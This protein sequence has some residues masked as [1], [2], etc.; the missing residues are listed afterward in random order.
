MTISKCYAKTSLT[1]APNRDLEYISLHYTA[2]TTSR[3]GSA[4]N[5]AQWFSDGGNPDNPASSDFIVD[6]YEVVQYNED[7]EN[8]YSWCVG[9]SLY[10][11]PTTSLG[12]ILYGKA[13][14]RNTINIEICSNKRNTKS[15]RAEDKD[16][17]FTDAA[18]NNA[19]ALVK[20]LMARYKIP[21]DHVI[22][23]HHVTGKP[24]PAMWTHEEKELNGYYDFIAKIKGKPIAQQKQEQIS[25]KKKL[26]CV[27]VGAFGIR[28]NAE[29]MLQEVKEH[30]P[31]AF[32]KEL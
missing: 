18:L 14:N 30:Y 16:W 20:Y 25:A 23:H 9:G 8:Y 7:I 15:L 22:M 13:K 6:D 26:Y 21:A 27:Q 1:Y 17:Y 12:G 32:I 19:E 11:N 5:T 29:K 3:K 28:S 2:G 31:N 10:K 24:C 4:R